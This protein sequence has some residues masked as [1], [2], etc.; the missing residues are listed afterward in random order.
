MDRGSAIRPNFSVEL[1]GILNGVAQVV[2]PSASRR[3]SLHS[4]ICSPR[5]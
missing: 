5:R 2:N 4:P 3:F 1:A